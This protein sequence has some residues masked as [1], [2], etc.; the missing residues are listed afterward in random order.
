MKMYSIILT[1]ED[2]WIILNTTATVTEQ[3]QG[4]S[5]FK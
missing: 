2:S 3:T 5:T 4:P 1:I